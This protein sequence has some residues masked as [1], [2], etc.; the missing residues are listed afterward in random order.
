MVT[1]LYLT[2]RCT[3]IQVFQSLFYF[4]VFNPRYHHSCSK[5]KVQILL[6]RIQ[7]SKL[8]EQ[9]SMFTVHIKVPAQYSMFSIKLSMFN[10]QC[11][12]F[13]VHAMTRVQCS[14]VNVQCLMIKIQ[15]QSSVSNDQSSM[16]NVWRKMLN[17]N[18]QCSFQV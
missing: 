16:F 6:F 1:V 17:I 13:N 2:T 18:I 7:C 5:F 8:Y 12:M 15:F 3:I 4:D 14:M 11:S 9:R 10:V